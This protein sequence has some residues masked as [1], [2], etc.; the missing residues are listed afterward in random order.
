MGNQVVLYATFSTHQGALKAQF[1]SIEHLVSVVALEQIHKAHLQTL[2]LGQTI[3]ERKGLISAYNN[4]IKTGNKKLLQQQLSDPLLSGHHLVASLDLLWLRSYNQQYQLVAESS[5][6]VVNQ[7]ENLP[8]SIINQLTL[9]QSTEKMQ[10]YG[11]LW[12]DKM[13]NPYYSVI[14]PIGGLR[15]LGYLEVIINP[16]FNLP[17]IENMLQMPIHISRQDGIVRFKSK[18]AINK[19]HFMPVSYWLKDAENKNN[20]EITA[21]ANIAL[22]ESETHKTNL[23]SVTILLVLTTLLLLLA[24]ALLNHFLFHP[25]KIMVSKLDEYENS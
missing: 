18:Q 7:F 6:A 21:F 5:K 17:N 2:D 16:L 8:K 19:E 10:A 23:Q 1:T 4:Y 12:Q 13:S 15:P 20:I 25:L 22:L 24:I 9:R 3:S 11:A 14:L